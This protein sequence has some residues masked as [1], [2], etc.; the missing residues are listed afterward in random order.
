M[1]SSGANPALR[2]DFSGALA[3]PGRSARRQLISPASCRCG[4]SS[5]SGGASSGCRQ[6]CWKSSGCVGRWRSIKFDAVAARDQRQQDA[7]I[8][9]QRKAEEERLRGLAQQASR[10]AAGCDDEGEGR[11][12]TRKPRQRR[13]PTPRRGRQR[14]RRQMRMLRRKPN[15][16]AEY[17]RLGA[18]SLNFNTLPG[19]PQ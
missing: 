6:A 11:K 18:G 9:Q 17:R 13:T 3:T 19:N 7:V 14:R 2:L 4:L 12:P 1:R 8:E 10:A 5:A 16:R 15:H